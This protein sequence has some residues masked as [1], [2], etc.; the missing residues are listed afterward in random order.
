MLACDVDG[1]GPRL[2]L[3]HGFSQTSRTWGPVAVDLAT[4]HQVVRVDAPGHGRSAH[5]QA[6]LWEGAELMVATAGSGTYLGYSM[7]GRLCLHAALA[8]PSA[9]AGLILLGTT[10]GIEAPGERA[11]RAAADEAWARRLEAEGID[12][13]LRS[14]LAQ[15]L[16]DGLDDE[17]A[18]LEARRENTAKGLA[19]SLRRAGTGAQEPLWDRL[20]A[21]SAPVLVLAGER[22]ARF[23]ALS[24]RLVD[25]I[26]ANAELALIPGAGHAAH[27]EAP[28]AV[29]AVV[30][31]WL[32]AHQL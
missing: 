15:P 23:V 27:L 29:L 18:G 28:G 24:E 25:S 3:V 12:A 13:F 1:A 32:D 4:D 6:G 10:A 31:P 5:H 7:G 22:D 9:V 8:Y 30:R 20:G 16:F 19:A 17:R 2:V 21:L 11:V 14:W 26:G